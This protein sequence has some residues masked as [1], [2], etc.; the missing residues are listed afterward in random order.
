M[1][2][3]IYV[4]TMDM[5]LYICSISSAILLIV[6]SFYQFI[7]EIPGTSTLSLLVVEVLV[8]CQICCVKGR[9]IY[10]L[11]LKYNN[12]WV[13]RFLVMNFMCMSVSSS[14]TLIFVSDIMGLVCTEEVQHI[15]R[16]KGGI[17]LLH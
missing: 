7:M 5:D 6:D 4:V 11:K 3:S 9:N 16:I 12:L 8:L 17:K 15:I 1:H 2:F 14:L 13:F 10:L